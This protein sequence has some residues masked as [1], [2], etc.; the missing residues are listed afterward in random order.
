MDD[1][2]FPTAGMAELAVE[3][4]GRAGISPNDVDVA[5]LYDHFSP[6]VLVQLED[7][8]F[9]GRGESGGFA[10]EGNIRKG[11]TLPVNT[12]GGNISEAYIIG[13][14]HV[15][16]G[17]EQIRGSAINQVEGAEVALVTGGPSHLPASAL[18]LHR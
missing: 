8:G 1:D 6:S 7:F 12:H 4:Y 18:L 11:G 13:L 17:V 16:E 2:L 10:A 9:C 5:L 15:V 14:T 3:L